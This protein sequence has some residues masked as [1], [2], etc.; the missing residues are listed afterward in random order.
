MQ[1]SAPSE[2]M[3]IASIFVVR[4]LIGMGIDLYVPSLPAIADYFN[5][6]NHLVQFTICFYVL[7]YG[8][9]QVF[10]GTL[11]D[12]LGRRKILL[13]SSLSF[14]VISFL[15]VFSW[16]IYFLIIY[17]FLQGLCIAGLGSSYR[18]IAVDCFTGLKLSKVMSYISISWALGPILGPF[19]GGYLQHYFNW[20]ASFYF[21]SLY[22]LVVFVYI[23][24]ALPETLQQLQPLC[25]RGIYNTSK[26]I[27]TH[28]IFIISTTLLTLVYAILIIFNIVGP[29]LIQVTLGYS[30]V[31]YGSIAL[32]IGAAYFLGTISN[33]IIINYFYPMQVVLVSIVIALCISLLTIFINIIIGLNVYTI[34]IPVA[35]LIFICGFIFSNIMAKAIG[36]FPQVAGTASAM[37]GS[38]VATGTFLM[39]LIATVL[40]SNTQFPL[41]ITYTVSLFVSLILFML[42]LYL[43][44]QHGESV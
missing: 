29:F 23:F 16:N 25:L 6:S 35:V 4:F 32:F 9:G 37:F 19:I 2:G 39:T 33:R 34:V 44:K 14:S 26:Y 11:S 1:R 5:V 42:L 24:I 40:K 10:L 12:S 15:A 18:A 41:F 27:I 3:I 20:Q 36:L 17:R 38:L 13:L 22:G 8:I 21:F 28:P 30:A 43:N 7:G 31:Y